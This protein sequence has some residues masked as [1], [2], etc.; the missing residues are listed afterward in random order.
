MIGDAGPP[1]PGVKFAE[2][3]AAP[4]EP[5]VN[6]AVVPVADAGVKLEVVQL[7]NVAPFPAVNVHD[8]VDAGAI[9]PLGG[10]HKTLDAILFTVRVAVP[11][12]VDPAEAVPVIVTVPAATPVATPDALIVA[13]AAFELPQVTVPQVVTLLLESRHVAVNVCVAPT[14]IVALD[15]LTESDFILAAKADAALEA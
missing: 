15:G 12:G 4:A 2:M 6:V 5:A 1:G 14:L 10:A 13:T 8:T 3:E 7:T 9:V 11:L